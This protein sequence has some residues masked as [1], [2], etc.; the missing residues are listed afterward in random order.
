VPCPTI[1]V[2]LGLFLCLHLVNI[3]TSEKWAALLPLTSVS[4]NEG[5]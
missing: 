4:F 1:F 3:N 5:L 2:S